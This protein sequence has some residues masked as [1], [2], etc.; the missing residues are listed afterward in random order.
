MG[1]VI[2]RHD[3][4][5]GIRT[6]IKEISRARLEKLL[7]EH[8]ENTTDKLLGREKH[9]KTV[10]G[11]LEKDAIVC[12]KCQ[13]NWTRSFVRNGYSARTLCT[14]QGI[15]SVRLPVIKCKKCGKKF[16]LNDYLVPRYVHTWYDIH[17]LCAE[18]YGSRCSFG[19]IQ[20]ILFRTFREWLGKYT[21]MNIVRRVPIL[22][23]SGSCPKELGLDAFWVRSGTEKDNAVVLIATNNDDRTLMD[24]MWAES[25]SEQSWRAFV[26][27]LEKTF[28][29]NPKEL[30][31][32]VSDGNQGIL[33]A[34]D[35]LSKYRTLCFFHILQNIQQNARDKNIGKE[36]MKEAA[37]IL[38]KGSF[39]EV[40]KALQPFI[41]KWQAKEPS[42][43]HNFFYSVAKTQDA[44]KLTEGFST[45]NNITENVI[46]QIRRKSK[47]MDNF[48][49][50]KTTYACLE[51]IKEQIG[52]FKQFGDWFT[53][54]EKRLVCI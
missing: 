41:K 8:I 53:P 32:I 18:L 14:L 22:P 16:R 15:V 23:K 27:R 37:A 9:R 28:S 17:S 38:K 10:V 13:E 2:D 51:M 36:M 5:K 50:Q 40:Q 20:Q 52:K 29:L 31:N 21:L 43:M 24:F 48:R 46:R 44:W 19:L 25:E 39:A 47:Q 49:S 54:I 26:G 11:K 1:I 42:A 6:D 45:T 34:T 4:F 3:V 33:K 35:Y 12:P 7:Q 30:T